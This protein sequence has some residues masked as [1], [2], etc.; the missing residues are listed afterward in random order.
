MNPYIRIPNIT[1][2]ND[3]DQTQAGEAVDWQAESDAVNQLR[4]DGVEWVLYVPPSDPPTELS[5]GQMINFPLPPP[6]WPTFIPGP[7]VALVRE[8]LPRNMI[9]VGAAESPL[10]DATIADLVASDF[11]HVII[12]FLHF[13]PHLK[14]V[15]NGPQEV[16]TV[17][18]GYW[19]KLQA[20]K[21]GDKP[22][23]LMISLGG[24]GSGSWA[25]MLGKEQQ[26]ASIL[27]AFV[28]DHGFDG[29]DI[30]FEGG[31]DYSPDDPDYLAS[32]G[33]LVVQLR[34]GLPKGFVTITPMRRFEQAQLQ[35]IGT[36]A[37]S[38]MPSVAAKQVVSWVNVQFDVYE[39]ERPDNDEDLVMHYAGLTT[40][41]G[42]PANQLTA[43]FGLLGESGASPA[44]VPGYAAEN[45]EIMLA[46]RD[47]IPKLIAQFPN[48]GGVFVWNYHACTLSG[49]SDWDSTMASAMS[50]AYTHGPIG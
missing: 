24:Y 49:K 19:D 39:N 13:N 48:F 18:A 44:N 15:Y 35:S 16:E 8:K 46:A 6:P 36:A 1:F 38:A 20:L 28:T 7:Y 37:A 33:K 26:A 14:L 42:L 31:P 47:K 50:Q 12:C 32:V 27:A 34:L 11:T 41:L 10:S 23:T 2:P 45:L 29:V 30:N 4:R 22:K 5:P 43:G 40:S 17:P 25:A 9:W 21:Q 3:F